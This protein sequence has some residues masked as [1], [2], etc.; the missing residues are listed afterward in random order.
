[1]SQILLMPKQI[2]ACGLHL[3]IHPVATYEAVLPSPYRV[4]LVLT[5][6]VQPKAPEI[7]TLISGK[8]SSYKEQT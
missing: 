7:Q 1:M 4:G 3:Y 5:T 2:Q 6:T 8:C